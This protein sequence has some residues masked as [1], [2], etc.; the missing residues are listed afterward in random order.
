MSE[1]NSE[2]ELDPKEYYDA[3]KKI[4]ENK[5][6]LIFQNRTLI[7]HISVL[8]IILEGAKDDA[9]MCCKNLDMKFF[10]NEI[11]INSIKTFLANGNK[12]TVLVNEEDCSEDLRKTYRGYVD[13]FFVYFTND[14]IVRIVEDI[15]KEGFENELALICGDAFAMIS[16]NYE[17]STFLTACFNN[18]IIRKKINKTIVKTI[19]KLERVKLITGSNKLPKVD[20]VLYKFRG[21]PIDEH[22]MRDIV[23]FAQGKTK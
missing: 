2:K 19:P 20:D 22:V 1:N 9:I 23:E 4:Y 10:N 17:E 8:K 6:D 12:L 3:L 21:V 16:S 15:Y 5:S 7:N 14:D 13:N 11:V 18:S